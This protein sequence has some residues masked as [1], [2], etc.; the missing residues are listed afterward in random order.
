MIGSHYELTFH[1][2]FNFFGPLGIKKPMNKLVFFL[3]GVVVAFILI[4]LFM[5]PR[6][7]TVYPTGGYRPDLGPYARHGGGPYRPGILY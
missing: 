3:F 1:T 6:W 7:Y 5:K 4:A 2:P